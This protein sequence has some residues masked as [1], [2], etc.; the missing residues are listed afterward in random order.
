L[1]F[2]AAALD[3]FFGILLAQDCNN[4]LAKLYIYVIK[5]KNDKKIMKIIMTKK[6][7]EKKEKKKKNINV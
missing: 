7:K 5:H 3:K 1:L 4:A 2:D 6:K